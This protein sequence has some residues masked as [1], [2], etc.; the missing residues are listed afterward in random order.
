ML[1]QGGMGFVYR[2]VH[3]EFANTVALKTVF[4]PNDRQLMSIQREIQALA[5]IRHPG[6]VKFWIKGLRTESHGTPW[7]FFPAII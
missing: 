1:G 5:R 2:A 6:V 4:V 3:Q 7:N